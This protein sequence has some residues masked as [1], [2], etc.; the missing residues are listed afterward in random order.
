MSKSKLDLE[1][2]SLMPVET[3]KSICLCVR[4]D[5]KIFDRSNS[6]RCLP[7]LFAGPTNIFSQEPSISSSCTPSFA[8]SEDAFGNT[9]QIVEF[10]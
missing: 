5:E 3:A 4:K 1:L 9:L 7:N 2:P 8:L 6:T 10:G